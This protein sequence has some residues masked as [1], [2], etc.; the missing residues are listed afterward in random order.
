VFPKIGQKIK[1]SLKYGK[2]SGY[3]TYIPVHIYVN[4]SPN[5]SQIEECFR[6]KKLRIKSKHTFWVQ[7]LFFE[8]RPVYEKM[9]ENIVQRGWPQMRIGRKRIA[10]WIPKATNTH[11]HTIRNTHCFPTATMA[12]RTRFNVTLY[13][14]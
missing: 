10:C 9:W 3:F 12:A 14:G 1:V 5:S 11:T 13:E 2:K 8:N 7:Y 4:I 6:K